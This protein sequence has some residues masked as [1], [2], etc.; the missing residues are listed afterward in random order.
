MYYKNIFKY[1]AMRITLGI[2][3]LATIPCN[4][5]TWKDG[6]VFAVG[7]GSSS[8][9]AKQSTFE[10]NLGCVVVSVISIELL[11]EKD[12]EART[13]LA[14]LQQQHA[15]SAKIKKAQQKAVWKELPDF[16]KKIGFWMCGFAIHYVCDVNKN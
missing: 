1:H 11:K 10:S 13:Q 7:I 5:I 2:M 6:V 3:L 15:E 4:A 9:L 8:L 16:L 12:L 14:L